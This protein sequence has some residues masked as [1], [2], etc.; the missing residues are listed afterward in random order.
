[1]AGGRDYDVGVVEIMS[2][3]MEVSTWIPRLK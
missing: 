3:K 2:Y 1:M